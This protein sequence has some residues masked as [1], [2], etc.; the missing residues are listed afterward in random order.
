MTLDQA[1]WDG[2]WQGSGSARW[3]ACFTLPSRAAKHAKTSPTV[4]PMPSAALPNMEQGR[5]RANEYAEQGRQ[6]VEQGRQKAA[7]LVEQG[8]QQA[9]EY[10]DKGR[11]YYE[12]GRTQWSQ[13][14]DKGKNMVGDQQAKASAAVDAAKDAYQSNPSERSTG[15]AG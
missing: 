1:V 3:L 13:Y 15:T 5:Q 7:D 14:V 12:K 6:L 10:A 4:Q 2:F 9:S 8:K 11:E